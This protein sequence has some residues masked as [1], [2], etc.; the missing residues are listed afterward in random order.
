[1][2][3]E[4]AVTALY[5]QLIGGWN[6][7]SGERFAAPF[8]DDGHVIGYDGSEQSGREQIASEMQRIF[9]DHETASYVANVRSVQLLGDDAALLR[10][11]VGMIPPGASELNPERNAHQTVVA[12]TRDGEWRIVLFQNTP[13]QFH[14][15]PELAEALTDELRRAAG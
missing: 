13:A 2:S 3:D 4:Q 10:A 6:E 5:E 11:V 14:G 12:T 7:Q 15:R 9:D 8:A 1:M